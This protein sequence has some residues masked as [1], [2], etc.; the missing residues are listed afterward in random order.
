[1]S[2]RALA[3]LVAEAPNQAA[4]A[5]RAAPT[6][7]LDELQQAFVQFNQLSQ[8]LSQSYQLL[9]AQVVQL[10]GELA[11]ESERRLQELAAK[12]RL[13]DQLSSLLDILPV[14]VIL[15][16]TQG[17]VQRINPAAMT[18]LS[19]QQHPGINDFLHCSWNQLIHRC[20][21]PDYTDGHEVA[22]NNGRLVSLSICA[23]QQSGQL[24]VLVDQTQTR[25]L[26]AKLSHDQ[27]LAAMGKMS[28]ALAHQIRTPLSAALL[29]ADNL[30]LPQIKAQQRQQFCQRLKSRLL[31]L[32]K[33]VSDMLLLARGDLP[34]AQQISAQ[35]LADAVLAAAEASLLRHNS[36]LKLRIKGGDHRIACTLTVLVSAIQ[37]LI[38]NALEALAQPGCIE[39]VIEPLGPWLQIMVC[40]TGPGIDPALIERISEPFF[41]TKAEGTGLGLA[42]VQTVCSAHGGEFDIRSQAGCTQMIV[43]LPLL[44]QA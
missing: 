8:Q 6:A 22:L 13:A 24:I 9:E 28:A 4:L 5:G 11:H 42:V 26:Q 19:T 23:L 2:N 20:I 31:N 39:L 15:L 35:A 18:L 3:S 33:Q 29:Y 27:R 37:N 25:A 7:K 17:R 1:M 10:S 12:E 34:L 16:N 43:R 21:K 44:V 30:S 38:N 14:G 40:D 41:S 32:D 36:R